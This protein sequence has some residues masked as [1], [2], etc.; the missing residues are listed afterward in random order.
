MSLFLVKYKCERCGEKWEMENDC[1]CD[2]R[3]PSC[4][5]VTEAYDFIHTFLLEHD[6]N[7]YE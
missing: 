4:D 7:D 3:C 2:D 6:G 5:K 1:A